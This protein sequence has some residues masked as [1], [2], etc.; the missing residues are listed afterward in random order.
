ML[1]FKEWLNGLLMDESGV[2]SSKRFMG[3]LSGVILCASLLINL[4]TSYPVDPILAQSVAA[5][6]FG[7]LGLSSIDKIWAVRPYKGKIDNEEVE[8][9]N[10]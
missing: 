1:K 4:F 9:I 10:S 3:L 7:S 2:P 5:L 6:A 8:Q